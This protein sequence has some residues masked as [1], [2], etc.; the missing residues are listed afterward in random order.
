MPV[1]FGMSYWLITASLCSLYR[2]ERTYTPADIPRFNCTQTRDGECEEKYISERG[3]DMN[4]HYLLPVVIYFPSNNEG[5]K[6]DI[7]TLKSWPDIKFKNP[8]ASLMLPVKNSENTPATIVS[9]TPTSQT[10]LARGVGDF[11]V[12]NFTYQTDGVTI[13]P[14]KSKLL[15]DFGLFTL[16]FWPSLF[17]PFIIRAVASRWRRRLLRDTA[18]A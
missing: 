18:P 15:R 8:D 13:I 14:I 7:R 9:S 16:T 12:S 2:C 17:L 3:N 6:F 1:T 10:I 4:P 5:R 11:H